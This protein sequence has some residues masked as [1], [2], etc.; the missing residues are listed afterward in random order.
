VLTTNKAVV[1]AL[2]IFCDRW[3]FYTSDNLCDAEPTMFK[4][5]DLQRYLVWKRNGYY[6][7]KRHLWTRIAKFTM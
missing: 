7:K 6:Y 1:K 4:H 2:Q 3:M 5:W